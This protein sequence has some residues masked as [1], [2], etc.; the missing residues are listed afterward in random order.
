MYRLVFSDR[1]VILVTDEQGDKI[2]QAQKNTNPPVYV[3]IN[4]GQ[5]RLDKIARIEHVITEPPTKQI[6]SGRK[7]HDKPIHGKIF[8]LYQVELKKEQPR[9]W[10]EFRA[11]A[12]DYLY[13]QDPDWC[14]DR[15]G[16]CVCKNKPSMPP[17]VDRVKEVMDF[18]RS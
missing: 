3:D 4:K 7:V 16:T 14:D 9:P 17:S 6:T 15:K 13:T 1:N 10:E 12:Y 8:S 2:K 18:M 5:Y 11:K